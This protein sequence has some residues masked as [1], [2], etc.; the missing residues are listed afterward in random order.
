MSAFIKVSIT[1]P[2][3][4]GLIITV[5][6]CTPPISQVIGDMLGYPQEKV[7]LMVRIL[8]VTEKRISVN[9]PRLI[10]Q[11]DI[12]ESPTA[13]GENFTSRLKELIDAKCQQIKKY[14]Y[15]LVVR[16]CNA[17]M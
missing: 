3:D 8:S 1:N 4:S 6:S 14:E 7:V 10:L 17:I 12:G 5:A 16:S 2:D 11:V 15:A 9:L 13:L